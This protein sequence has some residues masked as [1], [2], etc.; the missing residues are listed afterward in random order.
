[1]MVQLGSREHPR[2]GSA[3]KKLG[4]LGGFRKDTVFDYA[5]GIACLAGSR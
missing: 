2:Y 5:I 4:V 1:M 3:D